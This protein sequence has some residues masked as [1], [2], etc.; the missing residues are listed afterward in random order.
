MGRLGY[1]GHC[2]DPSVTERNDYKRN[3][4]SEREVHGLAKDRSRSNTCG[5]AVAADIVAAGSAARMGS[6][7]LLFCKVC[8]GIVSGPRGR[9]AALPRSADFVAKVENRTTTKISR[10]SIF[11]RLQRCKAPWP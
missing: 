4:A 2:V 7:Y 10:K 3:H 5:I 6:F 11:K 8:F 9:P 1:L